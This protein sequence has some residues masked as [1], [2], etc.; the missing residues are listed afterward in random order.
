MSENPVP[1][2]VD[3]RFDQL[4]ELQREIDRAWDDGKLQFPE[5]HPEVVQLKARYDKLYSEIHGG[6]A[7]DRV[8]EVVEHDDKLMDRVEGLLERSPEHRALLKAS[9]R[10]GRAIELEKNPGVR[11]KILSALKEEDGP[12]HIKQGETDRG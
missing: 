4:D 1:F 2:F 11:G 12:V 6:D 7:L 9:T 8:R 10:D 3:R 5:D